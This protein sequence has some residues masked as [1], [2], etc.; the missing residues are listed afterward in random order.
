MGKAA[1]INAE[2]R[3]LEQER[4]NRDM[5]ASNP[6]LSRER[7]ILAQ[8][9]QKIVDEAKKRLSNGDD[10]DVVKAWSRQEEIRAIHEINFMRDA[11]DLQPF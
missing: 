11:A 6:I 1:R 7:N 10:V 8:K 2:K 5:I 3:R 4:Y 9:A